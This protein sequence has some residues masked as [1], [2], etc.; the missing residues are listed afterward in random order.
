MQG[1]HEQAPLPDR[2]LRQLALLGAAEARDVPPLLVTDAGKAVSDVR[3]WETER[4]RELEA[5][6]LENEY[7]VLPEAAGKAILAQGS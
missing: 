5:W 1:R 4:R 7:G 6:F 2:A 3:T